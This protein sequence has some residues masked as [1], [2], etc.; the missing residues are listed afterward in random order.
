MKREESKEVIVKEINLSESGVFYPEDETKI[1]EFFVNNENNKLIVDFIE[2]KAK[3]LIVDVSSA[4]GRRELASIAMNIAKSKVRIDDVGKNLTSKYKE[5]P[6]KIDAGRKYI[7]DSLDALKD[8]VR[9]PLTS[10]ENEQERIK[11]EAKLKKDIEEAHEIALLMNMKFDEDLK[12]K[13]ARQEREKEEQRKKLEIEIEN[14]LR[15]EHETKMRAEIAKI[16]SQI[17]EK[18]EVEA[19]EAALTIQ[20]EVSIS[21]AVKAADEV[22]VVVNETD[23]QTHVKAVNR[24]IVEQLIR[25][26]SISEDTA[27]NIVIAIYNRRIDGLSVNY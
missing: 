8:K 10:W 3:D 26:V 27:R 1:L 23:M 14:R 15:L 13:I 24:K 22:V 2:S 9:E 6:K 5:M 20:K 16:Q 11:A 25:E 18:S 12:E 19:T 17:N 21:E 7:R 4:K